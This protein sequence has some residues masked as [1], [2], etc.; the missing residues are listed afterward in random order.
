MITAMKSTAKESILTYTVSEED[1]KTFG[2]EF[3]IICVVKDT[4]GEQVISRQA[5]VKLIRE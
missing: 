4:K 2:T 5:K 3:Y 1:I